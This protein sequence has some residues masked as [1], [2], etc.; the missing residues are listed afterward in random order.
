MCCSSL[1]I[2]NHPKIIFTLFG[3]WL[4][5]LSPSSRSQMIVSLAAMRWAFRSN[6][7]IQCSI[8]RERS[9][10]PFPIP[11]GCTPAGECG[12]PKYFYS[13]IKKRLVQVMLSKVLISYKL[14]FLLETVVDSL[15]L[16]EI[17]SAIYRDGCLCSSIAGNQK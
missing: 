17:K 15:L 8:S 16:L 7:M 1:S 10:G 5:N 11:I 3:S 4:R 6:R 12:R 2:F 13:L 14:S 9:F